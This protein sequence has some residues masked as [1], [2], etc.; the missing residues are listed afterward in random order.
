LLHSE[1]PIEALFQSA[2][3]RKQ[4]ISLFV[5]LLS[6]VIFRVVLI[7][8]EQPIM[9]HD[10][11]RSAIIPEPEPSAWLERMKA[12]RG[13][14]WL[15]VADELRKARKAWDRR[16]PVGRRGNGEHGRHLWMN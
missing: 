13:D 7:H 11:D 14:R 12:F 9:V 5:I 6:Q 15:P 8:E 16:S 4:G 1:Q 2:R 10:A 3:Q